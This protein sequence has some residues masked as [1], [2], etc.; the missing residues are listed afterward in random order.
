M[1]NLKNCMYH[2]DVLGSLLKPL[3]WDLINP[4]FYPDPRLIGSF[5][6]GILW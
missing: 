2:V 5:T 4:E 3:N 1:W 6:S